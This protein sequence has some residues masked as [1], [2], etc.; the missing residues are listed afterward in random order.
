MMLGNDSVKPRYLWGGRLRRQYFQLLEV[1]KFKMD[2]VLCF[3]I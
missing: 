3:C 1:Y 2:V